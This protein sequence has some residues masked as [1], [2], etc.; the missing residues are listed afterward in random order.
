[1]GRLGLQLHSA[2]LQSADYWPHLPAALCAA[3]AAASAINETEITRSVFHGYGVPD[4]G[5]VPGAPASVYL[6]HQQT[7]RLRTRLTLAAARTLLADH[8]W[9]VRPN[10]TSTLLQAR[11]RGQ[12]VRAWRARGSEACLHAAV[13]QWPDAGKRGGRGPSQTA[14]ASAGIA[15]IALKAA[16]MSA[17]SGQWASCSA[18]VLLAGALLGETGWGF[19]HPMFAEP[20]GETKYSASGAAANGGGYSSAEAD[21]LMTAV[22]TQGLGAFD[23]SENYISAQVPV[24]WMASPDYFVSAIKVATLPERLRR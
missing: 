8:G 11:N 5:P 10:G 13:R 7:L 12:C 1:M 21:S 17:V 24:L 9:T 4:Y 18:V 14:F 20:S 22:H 23:K 15:R 16:L 3:S 19:W 6:S 2:E